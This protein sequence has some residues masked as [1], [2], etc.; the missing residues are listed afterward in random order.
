[1][2]TFRTLIALSAALCLGA[3]PAPNEFADAAS[4]LDTAL[5]RNY[6][7]LD[8]LPGSQIPQSDVLTSE[9][10]A[11]DD[12][13]SLLT[14]AE[15]R[16]ASL[17]DHHATTGSSFGDSWALVP[18]YA[19][20]WI[21][22]RDGRFI[23]DAVREDSPAE[24][25]GI[26]A[27][28]F[29]VAV[30]GVPFAQ[31]LSQFWNDLGLTHTQ[32]RAEY[33]ARVLAAGRRDRTRRIS[34]QNA[35]RQVKELVLPSLYDQQPPALP[36]ISMCQIS[37][38]TVIRIN[39]SLGDDAVIEAFGQAMRTIPPA[40]HL[41][42]DLRDTP[43]GGNTTVARGI[44]GWFVREPHAYQIHNRP[45][46]ERETGIARQW[47]EQVLPRDGMY[48]ASLPTVL[49]GR[50]T[51]SMG[52]GLAIGFASMGAH[53][54]GSRM[55]GL[56]GS[57]EDLQV[58]QTDLFIKLP[59]E[60]LLTTRGQPREEFVPEPLSADNSYSASCQTPAVLTSGDELPRRRD[61]HTIASPFNF[62][63]GL[64]HDVIGSDG[65]YFTFFG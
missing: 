16:I 44:M 24:R 65:V 25:A 2:D 27:G 14:Y 22:E 11:V 18:T 62:L 56:K 31:A 46:E 52:E 51:G 59:T 57:I 35:A 32:I 23:V 30:D 3:A 12:A 58:G 21:V 50:W 55:A 15:R 37:G 47:I 63:R 19:D 5:A 28:D 29:V 41:I 49:V 4:E 6:A 20:L 54:R 10:L 33:A 38:S 43:S 26:T 64:A 61:M 48:R 45:A 34:V 9:R 40:H 7:Y 13:R 42:L 1:M 8:K 39:N 17:A 60:R 36:P 53:V